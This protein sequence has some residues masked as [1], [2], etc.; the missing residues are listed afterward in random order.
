MGPRMRSGITAQGQKFTSG[1]AETSAAGERF[2]KESIPRSVSC[3][4]RPTGL[5]SRLEKE[6]S[7]PL[8]DSLGLW[9]IA[10]NDWTARALCCVWSFGAWIDRLTA[11]GNDAVHH[12]GAWRV[13]KVIYAALATYYVSKRAHLA[14]AL[15]N[16]FWEE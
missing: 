12:G 14:Q 13:P 7:K 6:R 9:P 2:G 3:G 16:E 11:D 10:L 5:F 1:K 8:S 15:P 4:A